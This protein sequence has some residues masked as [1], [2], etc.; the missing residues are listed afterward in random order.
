[1]F[2]LKYTCLNFV[3]LIVMFKRYNVFYIKNIYKKKCTD[4]FQ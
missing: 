2:Q 4:L 1:M 3:K